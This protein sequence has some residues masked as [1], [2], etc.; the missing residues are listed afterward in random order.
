MIA[1]LPFGVNAKRKTSHRAGF[2]FEK[3]FISRPTKK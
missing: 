2:V 1:R 3:G